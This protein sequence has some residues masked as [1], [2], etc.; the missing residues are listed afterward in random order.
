M[1]RSL[2]A[3]SFT[4][5]PPMLIVPPEISSSP[6][7]MR[8]SVDLPQP[9]GPTSTRNSPS[10]TLRLT[11]WITLCGAVG[12]DHVPELDRRHGYSSVT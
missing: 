3:R 9:D 5:V 12:L 8:R 1:F 2:G 4:T 7:T 6:A 11:P 10:A